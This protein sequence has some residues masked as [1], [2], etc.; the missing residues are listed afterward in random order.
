MSAGR[1]DEA[2][3]LNEQIAYYRARAKEYDQSIGATEEPQEAFAKAAGLLRTMGPFEQVLELACGTGNWTRDL[4]QIG[5]EFTALDAAPEM[6]EIARRKLGNAPVRFERVNLF[7][8]EP[9]QEYDLVFFAFWLSHVPPEEL[10]AFLDKVRRAVRPGG[11]MVIVDQYAPT[12]ED[13]ELIKEEGGI[14]A[15]RPLRDGRTF[16]IV[17]VFYNLA[18]LQDTL[19]RL[20]FEVVIHKLDDVFFFLVARRQA[21]A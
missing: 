21:F 9:M 13:R 14:Y 12:L 3:M 20:G 15:Q 8:W 6:L 17:K 18:A 16:T 4:L 11:S 5:R 1:Q 10:D 2:V 19:E 7:Q